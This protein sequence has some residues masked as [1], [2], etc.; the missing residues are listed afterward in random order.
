MPGRHTGVLG[1]WDLRLVFGTLPKIRFAAGM[2]HYR[3]IEERDASLET[4]WA[5]I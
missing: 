5:S 1:C 3:E 4:K 2:T